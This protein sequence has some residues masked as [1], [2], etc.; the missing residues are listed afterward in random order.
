MGLRTTCF[1]CHV[2]MTLRRIHFWSKVK[3]SHSMFLSDYA[4]PSMLG[5]WCHWVFSSSLTSW[6]SSN[7]VGH[8]NC[9]VPNSDARTFLEKHSCMASPVDDGKLLCSYTLWDVNLVVCVHDTTAICR[10]ISVPKPWEALLFGHSCYDTRKI[11][12]KKAT[13]FPVNCQQ[14]VLSFVD[15]YRCEVSHKTSVM[16]TRY[17]WLSLMHTY[18]HYYYQLSLLVW[19][20]WNIWYVYLMYNNYALF[21]CSFFAPCFFKIGKMWSL[22]SQ[23]TDGRSFQANN[24]GDVFQVCWDLFSAAFCHQLISVGLRWFHV[25][26]MMFDA[27]FLFASFNRFCVCVCVF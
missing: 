13:T 15:G 7:Y 21:I 12:T 2:P 4:A 23:E 8:I 25:Y 10:S 18:I 19:L 6:C 24:H 26:V 5:V 16:S 1:A 9:G 11:W 27:S 14:P 22:D 17:V 20:L 3:T